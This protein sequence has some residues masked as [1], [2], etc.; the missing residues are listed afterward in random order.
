VEKIWEKR[1][2]ESARAFRVFVVYRNLPPSERNFVT[3]YALAYKK[4]LKEYHDGI[5]KVPGHIRKWSVDYDWVK[6]AEAWDAYRDKQTE[7]KR[8]DEWK[9]FQEDSIK[10]ARGLI[11]KGAQRI[12]DISTAEIPAAVLDK[13]V[14]NMYKLMQDICKKNENEK[15]IVEETQRV[16]VVGR[17]LV[18][19]VIKR[20]TEDEISD[21]PDE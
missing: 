21:E 6:R 15:L 3:A 11:S 13:W 1:D 5:K 14:L 4:N 10:Y 2:T 9:D 18:S 17:D 7:Q 19:D 20:F 12:I 8:I 16:S